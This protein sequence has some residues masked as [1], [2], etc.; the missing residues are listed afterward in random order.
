MSIVNCKLIKKQ[1]FE[2][3]IT[4]ILLDREYHQ[5]IASTIKGLILY[6]DLDTFEIKNTIDA[7]SPKKI[8][9]IL[10]LPNGDLISHGKEHFAIWRKNKK[11]CSFLPYKEWTRSCCYFSDGHIITGSKPQTELK[12][13]KVSNIFNSKDPKPTKVLSLSNDEWVFHILNIEDKY[14]SH[15][16]ISGHYFIR[17]YFDHSIF[18]EFKSKSFV[19]CII[20]TYDRNEDLLFVGTHSGYLVVIDT[21]KWEIKFEISMGSSIASI[22]PL[23]E[24]KLL[25]TLYNG[26]MTILDR[27]LDYYF[28]DT[29]TVTDNKGYV[30][31]SLLLA[32]D[33]IITGDKFKSICLWSYNPKTLLIPEKCFDLNFKF[34]K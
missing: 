23:P 13:W 5:L 28:L 6:L 29:F 32:D 20:Q 2:E 30:Y 25:V 11:I 18:K 27:K 12:I 14:Y 19:K 16:G 31:S 21:I 22:L 10:F 17:N 8:S 3:G 4:C 15:G 26:Q 34:K 24:S 9:K 33:L 7:C 1:F